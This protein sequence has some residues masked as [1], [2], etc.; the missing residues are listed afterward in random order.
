[1]GGGQ[2][3]SPGTGGGGARSKTIVAAVSGGG[4]FEWR[5]LASAAERHGVSAGRADAP[6]RPRR[7]CRGAASRSHI[8]EGLPRSLLE[9]AP[10]S[11]VRSVANLVVPTSRC[12]NVWYGTCYRGVLPARKG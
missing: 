5:H 4:V 3:R 9:S 12:S 1:P 10:Q 11:L 8:R 6:V 7:G 2:L